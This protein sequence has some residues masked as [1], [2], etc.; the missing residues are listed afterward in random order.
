MKIAFALLAAL[1]LAAC[2]PEYQEPQTIAEKIKPAPKPAIAPV[3][4]RTIPAPFTKVYQLR[5]NESILW[6]FNQAGNLVLLNSSSKTVVIT[7][8]NSKITGIDDGINPVKFHYDPEWR[9]IRAEKGSRQWIF[10]YTSKG[11]LV[12]MENGE[13]L[14]AAYDSKGRLSSIARDGG[15]AT[16]FEYDDYNR[17]KAIYKQNIKTDVYYDSKGRIAML[18][19]EDDHLV[20]G[21]WRYDLLSALSGTMYGLKETV[22]YGPSSITLISNV[23]QNEFT[24]Q[25]PED[26]EARLKA[27][28][29]FLFCKRF[30]KLPVLFDGQSWVLYHEYMKGD[31]LD[32]LL[33]GFVCEYLP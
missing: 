16:E 24:S 33:T 4:E 29:T 18:Q 30:K 14:S 26:S 17:T 10:S 6:G 11:K 27:F 3:P 23:D 9:V 21:Y 8:Q 32:Y 12:S 7:Y 1:F 2:V 20:I 19:H 15:T 31:V 5:G 25:Y 28:N 13:R 22:N